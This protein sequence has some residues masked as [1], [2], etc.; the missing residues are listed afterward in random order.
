M[1]KRDYYDV[2]GV[3][4]NAGADDIKKAYRK[5]AIQ[6]H[7][8]KNPGNAEAEEKFKE[9]SEAY[10]VLSD[11]QSRAKY[12]RFGHEATGAGYG[13]G[14]GADFNDIFSRF[15][16]IFEGTG[17]EGFFG[18]ARGGQRRAR[19]QRGAD[20]RIK[21][22]LTLEEIAQGTEKTLKIR[23]QVTCKSCAG[24]G[25]QD[26]S[27]HQTCPTCNGVGEVRQQVG[28]GFFSQIVVSACPTCNGEGKIITQ[29]CMACSGEGRVPEEQSISVNIPAGVSDGMQLSMRG[30]GNAGK[31]GG[32][33]GDLLVQF[34]EIPHEYLVRDGENV[35]FDLYVNFA[36]AALGANVEVPT[37]SGKA[38]FKVEPGT[39]SG[40]IK[41]LK[42]KGIP[43]ING[44]GAGDQLVHVNVW[45][46]R[47]LSSEEKKL[48]EKLRASDNFIPKPGKSDKGFFSKMKEFFGG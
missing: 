41:R 35:I 10:E 32:D 12:D 28:G 27:S 16:D 19:G 5:L 34:E 22:K 3:P 6:Y 13:G 45:T 11:E 30:Q 14:G 1:A 4:K 40:E 26:G 47:A 38:R 25:A 37:L 24:T 20:L 9:A 33:P 18:G 17:F 48:L 46:P 7:P 8:D 44:Y 21:L 23:R 2:L 43:N 42:G 15:S 39:Q 31:R 29:K 36:D